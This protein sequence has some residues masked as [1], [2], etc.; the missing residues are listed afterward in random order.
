MKK[1]IFLLLLSFLFVFTSNAQTNPA[2]NKTT[3]AP[4]AKEEKPKRQIFRAKKDIVN[5]HS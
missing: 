1:M 4:T 5:N 3:D 2:A